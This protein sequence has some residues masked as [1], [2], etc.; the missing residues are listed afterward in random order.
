MNRQDII[1]SAKDKLDSRLKAVRVNCRRNGKNKQLA[2]FAYIDPEDYDKVKDHNWHFYDGYVLT[3]INGKK[4]L[5]HRLITGS[6]KGMEVDHTTDPKSDNRKSNLR[7]CNCGENKRN[8]KKYKGS[9][10]DFKGVCWNKRD[11]KWMSQIRYNKKQIHL[12]YFDSEV[13]AAKAYDKKAL[14]LDPVFSLTNENL[15]LF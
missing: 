14:E 1:K 11:H 3:H 12:G 6:P 15:G 9:S 4:V 2:G 7:I 13:E 8:G 10:S 5:M